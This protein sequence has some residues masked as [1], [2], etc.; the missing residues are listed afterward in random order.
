MSEEKIEIPVKMSKTIDITIGEGGICVVNGCVHTDPR[1]GKKAAISIVEGAFENADGHKQHKVTTF[2]EAKKNILN[3]PG[4]FTAGLLVDT[5]AGI[6]KK[7]AQKL[8]DKM[9]VEGLIEDNGGAYS[10][11]AK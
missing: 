2:E 8:L 3:F 6:G 10:V 4:A 5:F 7:K 9:L 11:I 1:E